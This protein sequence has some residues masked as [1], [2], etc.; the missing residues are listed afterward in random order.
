MATEPKN[1]LTIVAVRGVAHAFHINAGDLTL[2][3][4]TGPMAL[5]AAGAFLI[6]YNDP[7]LVSAAFSKLIQK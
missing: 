2:V 1:D 7:G 5:S 3:T 4:V 6:H